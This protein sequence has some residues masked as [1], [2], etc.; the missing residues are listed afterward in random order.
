MSESSSY[1]E[2]NSNNNNSTGSTDSNNSCSSRT[3]NKAYTAR[4]VALKCIKT[5]T[6][7]GSCADFLEEDSCFMFLGV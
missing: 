1:T 6:T 4:I 5:S 2:I 3:S 7:K